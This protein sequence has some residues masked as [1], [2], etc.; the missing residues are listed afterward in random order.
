MPRQNIKQGQ[1]PIVAMWS[2]LPTVIVKNLLFN[3][4]Q[5][6]CFFIIFF[7]L[8]FFPKIIICLDILLLRL[9]YR[10]WKENRL[11]LEELLPLTNLCD[12]N[13]KMSQLCTKLH[14]LQVQIFSEFLFY[15][16]VIRPSTA[17]LTAACRPVWPDFEKVNFV[18]LASNSAVWRPFLLPTFTT[19]PH[20]RAKFP[21]VQYVFFMQLVTVL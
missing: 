20:L 18:T 6:W 19:H 17:R 11:S 12:L 15:F 4:D 9:K 13:F 10:Y 3:F 21:L 1:Q 8:P 14:T 2:V 7:Q 5:F 16:Q